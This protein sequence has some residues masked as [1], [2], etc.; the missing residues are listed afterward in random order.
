MKLLHKWIKKLLFFVIILL[1]LFIAL[2]IFIFRPYSFGDPPRIPKGWGYKL[3]KVFKGS[4]A[5]PKPILISNKIDHPY[6]AN[7]NS[8]TMHVDSYASDAHPLGGP[9]G[10]NPKVQSFAQGAFAGECACVTFDSRGNIVAVF[11]SFKEFALLLISPDNLKTLAKISLPA[12][13]SNKSLNIRRIMNDTS[14]G[15]YFFLDNKDRAVLVDANQYLKIIAQSWDGDHVHFEIVKKYSLM[16]I[17]IENSGP[18]DVITSVMPDWLGRYWFVSR[19]G[20]VGVLNP[21]TEKISVL[22]LYDE[23]I[24][25]SFAIDENSAY[26]VSNRALYGITTKSDNDQPFIVWREEYELAKR[27]KKGSITLGSGT[28][29]T[30]LGDDYIAIADNAEPQI[31]VLIYRR[32]MDVTGP[33]LICKVPVFEPEKSTTENTLI[34]IGNSLIVENNYGYDLFTNMIFGRTGV[35]GIAR[36]D[37]SEEDGKGNVVWYNP[38]IS[39]TTVPKISLENGLIYVYS[40]DPSVGWGVD[41]FYL[42]ALD[43][44]TGETIFEILT[45]TGVSY[46]NNWAP[47][48]LGPDNSAY[49]GVLRGL[50]KVS[51]G[52][53]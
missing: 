1:I 28:T 50:V 18:D 33:R 15:A 22:L 37:F 36:V 11:G 21:I 53:D 27:K 19:D 8:S 4:Q 35:G 46:D 7:T 41:A 14:G 48:T 45:G 47:I 12:R 13:K 34:G 16:D 42:S 17:L 26:I 23:E 31:N 44:E 32:G 39:Q 20:I 29:P 49:I 51:D 6:L 25:N 30:L 9:L 52:V 5:V 38:I 40:K 24:Q 3:A 2:L 43:F 10:K